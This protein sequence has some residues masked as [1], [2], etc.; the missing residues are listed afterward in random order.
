M[1]CNQ[2]GGKDW[3]LSEEHLSNGGYGL[4]RVVGGDGEVEVKEELFNMML[5][6]MWWEWSG[7][8]RGSISYEREKLAVEREGIEF[9]HIGWQRLWIRTRVLYWK[10]LYQDSANESQSLL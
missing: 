6:Y 2:A 7:R 10:T 5:G 4:L 8:K 3:R 9:S 1:G